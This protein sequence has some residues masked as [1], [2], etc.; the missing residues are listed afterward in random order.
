MIEWNE[1]GNLIIT[2]ILCLTPVVAWIEYFTRKG[3]DL[4]FENVETFKTLKALESEVKEISNW[5]GVGEG[6]KDD[7][8]SLNWYNPSKGVYDFQ[9][10][11]IENYIYT[12]KW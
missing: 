3:K 6:Y 2:S 8:F 9:D 7:Y 1:W 11:K 12:L 10:E 4:K 5:T